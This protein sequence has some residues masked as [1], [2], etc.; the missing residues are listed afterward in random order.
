[1]ETKLT[2][3]LE[4]SAIE[5]AKSYARKRNQSLSKLVEGFFRSLPDKAD[6]GSSKERL[7]PIVKELSGIISLPEDFDIRGAYTEY[8]EKKYK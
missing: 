5:K 4:K 2:L 3:K 8:L 6:E 7:T 1:M